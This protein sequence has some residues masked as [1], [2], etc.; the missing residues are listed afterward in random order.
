MHHPT[1]SKAIG[2]S[3]LFALAVAAAAQPDDPPPPPL[4]G[5]PV[6]DRNVPGAGNTFGEPMPGEKNKATPRVRPR[7]FFDA[8]RSLGSEDAPAHLHPTPEQREQLRA[9]VEEFMDEVRAFRE[10]NP[11]HNAPP[12]RGERAPP[13]PRGPEQQRADGPPPP[14]P[15]REQPPGE[16]RGAPGARRG[17]NPDGY[18]T[19]VWEVL[20]EEQ[21]A[22]L[23]ERLDAAKRDRLRQRE[24]PIVRE[25]GARQSAPGRADTRRQRRAPTDRPPSD[26]DKVVV[27]TPE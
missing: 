21:Q 22:F 10:Q 16:T 14:S 3:A 20:N 18:Y 7:V 4:G 27:P 23:R 2:L 19:R 26:M 9:V 6:H 13:P 17:P 5:P 15:P 1:I 25:G 11:D 8:L 12:P 24:A